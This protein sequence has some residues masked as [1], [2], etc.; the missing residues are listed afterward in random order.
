MIIIRP[1][2]VEDIDQ[3]VRLATMTSFGLSTLPVDQE[4]LEE[5]IHA[6]IQGFKQISKKPRGETYLLVMVDT[7]DGIIIGTSGMVSKVGGFE[8]FYAYR[9]DT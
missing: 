3:L 4:Y 2:R 9:V 6:S 7:H 1:S 5:R 8:P